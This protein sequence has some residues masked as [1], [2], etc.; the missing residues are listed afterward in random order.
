MN[1]GNVSKWYCFFQESRTVRYG[2]WHAHYWN[3]SSEKFFSMV[4][5]IPNLHHVCT[6]YFS[7]L[8]KF[9]AIQSLRSNQETKDIVQDWLK[10]LW[11][12]STK[13]YKEVPTMP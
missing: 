5:T 8:K 6:V 3:S 1:E 11:S 7:H 13:A 9:L 12:F 4:Y 10:G 2:T